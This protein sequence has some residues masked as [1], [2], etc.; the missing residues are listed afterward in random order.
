MEATQQ[1]PALG[2]KRNSFR[3]IYPY[4]GHYLSIN[5]LGY[6][7]LDE[8]AGQPVL[9]LHG[10]PTWS[11]YYRTLVDT[12]SRHYRTI[13]PDH[14]GCGFSEKPDGTRYGFR[15]EDRVSDLEKLI[16]HLA[17]TQKISLILHDW[18]GMIGLAFALRHPESIG[19]ITILNT[20]GFLPPAGKRIPW[21]LQV[22]RKG[23]I[24]AAIAVLGVNI[25]ARGAL[26]M[27]TRRKLTPKVKRGL[28]APYNSWHNRLAVLKFVQDIP[29]S[30]ND[31]SYSLV[32]FVDD[33]LHQLK[34]RP[35]LICWGE[36]DFVFDGDYL[37]EWCRRFPQ[38]E[39][40]RFPDAGHYI[41]ED[42]PQRV[43]TRILDFL[44][45]NPF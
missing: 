23:H 16:Q 14:I 39:V 29:I 10:N 2:F 15:L 13:V 33:N 43:S 1:R 4:Q 12:L 32:K 30:P 44:Q 17:L 26:Y 45:K 38:A 42:A 41:L 20:A 37:A 8:G 21:Q 24:M 11:F 28:L 18:G 7:Y 31:P 34:D 3:D 6:H 5:D 40:H 19:R 36:R 27:A 22:I 9:M 35:M 25:F